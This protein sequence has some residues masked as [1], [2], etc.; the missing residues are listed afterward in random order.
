MLAAKIIIAIFVWVFLVFEIWASEWIKRFNLYAHTIVLV[1]ALL[2]G[3]VSVG[4][5]QILAELKMQ[6]TEQNERSLQ[7]TISRAVTQLIPPMRGTIPPEPQ[8]RPDCGVR[9]VN[10]GSA[11]IVV[12]NRSK[13][14]L[15]SPQ[16]SVYIWDLDAGSRNSLPTY[17]Q[18]FKDK[19]LRPG[20]QTGDAFGPWRIFETFPEPKLGDRLFGYART[21]CPECVTERFYWIY[22]KYGESGW[23]GEMRG[24]GAPN[25]RFIVSLFDYPI[26]RQ[27]IVISSL[28]VIQRLQIENAF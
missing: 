18:L 21:T 12:Y 25:P 13:A 27:E 2:I 14:I 22:T 15:N 24:K 19:W 6:Q 16:Y 28:P 23:Y 3:L 8:E 1:A 26:D 20:G 4:F 9:V 10:P 5:M 17:E 11:A 7:Q